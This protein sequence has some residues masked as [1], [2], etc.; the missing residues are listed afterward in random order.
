MLFW[1]GS[2]LHIVLVMN[3]ACQVAVRWSIYVGVLMPAPMD[4]KS[5]CLQGLFARVFAK[6]AFF[7]LICGSTWVLTLLLLTLYG[8]CLV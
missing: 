4:W 1:S 2:P 5:C 8:V 3:S 6:N 7:R